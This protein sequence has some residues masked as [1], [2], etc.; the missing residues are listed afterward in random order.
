MKTPFFAAVIGLLVGS[1]VHA[2]EARSSIPDP[3]EASRKGDMF[4]LELQK[5]KER[6]TSADEDANGVLSRE[7]V[8]KNFPYIE[9][10]FDRYDLNKD[11]VLSWIEFSGQN[12]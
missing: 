9:K 2:Q 12:K 8:A 5:K 11:G 1:F 10:N 6:Y 4:R 3:S 7:E